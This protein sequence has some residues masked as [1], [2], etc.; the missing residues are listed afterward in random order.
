VRRSV[1][2]LD[3]EPTRASA[4][5]AQLQSAGFDIAPFF[6]AADALDRLARPVFGSMIVMADLHDADCCKCLV[7]LR[8]VAPT[9]WM[10][11]V[12]DDQLPGSVKLARKLGADA[13]LTTPFSIADLAQRLAAFSRRSRS[14]F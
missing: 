12:A 11:V 10:I 14:A 5:A 2:L 1:L 9:V 8:K 13:I 7:D 4:L 3:P 6:T